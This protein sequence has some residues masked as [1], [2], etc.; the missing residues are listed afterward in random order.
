MLEKLP[1]EEKAYEAF[2]VLADHRIEMHEN[3][4]HVSSSDRTKVYEV[5]WQDHTYCSTDSATYW[6]G[7]PGYPVIAVL[8]KQGRL[9]SNEQAEQIMQGINW[10]QM[11][12][13]H[14]HNYAE[15]LKEVLDILT[16]KGVD[17]TPTEDLARAVN[18]ALGSLDIEVKKCRRKY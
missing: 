17:V 4:A 3:Y 11:N 10:K 2:S 7:Y 6:Q 18:T 9:P 8:I 1:P 14:K 15:A 5:R 13:K 16:A 12:E